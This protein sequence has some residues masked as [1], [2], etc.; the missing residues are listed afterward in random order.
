VDISTPVF[1]YALCKGLFE[2]SVHNKIIKG[3][4][5]TALLVIDIARSVELFYLLVLKVK[6]PY[7]QKKNS[8]MTTMM[9]LLQW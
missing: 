3:A 2:T 8:L 9:F 1:S 4:Y 6:K 5:S 7:L